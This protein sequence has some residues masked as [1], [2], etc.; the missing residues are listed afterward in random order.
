MFFDLLVLMRTT[1]L[2]LAMLFVVAPCLAAEPHLL[3]DQF[4][5]PAGFHIYRA[6]NA[7]LTGGSYD[8]TLDGQGRLLVGAGQ[9]VRRLT[10]RNGDGVYD[11]QETIADGPAVAGRGPQ[12]LLVFGD[13]LYVVAGDGVQLFSG[14]TG[15]GKLRHERR[16]GAPFNTG[17]DHAAHTVLRG[18]DNYI[19]LVTGDGAGTNGRKHITET[20]SPNRQERAA[21]VF[22]FDAAGEK[23]ECIGSGGRNP[24]SLGMNYLGEFFSFDSDMEFHVDVPF[25]RP[26]RLNHWATGGDLGWQS[27]GAFPPWY[28][29]NLPGVL[30][31]G[32]GS[33]NWGVV[34]EHTQFP[35]PYRDAFIAC[36]YT[37]KSATSGRYATSGR[38]LTFHLQ[39]EGAGWKANL[40]ELAKAKPGAQDEAGRAINFALVDVAVAPDGSLLLS[41]H[42]QGV[43]RL[44]YD[45][46][47]RPT[48]PPLAYTPKVE[49]PPLS[50]LLALPQPAAEWCRILELDLR[51][52]LGKDVTAQLQEVATNQSAPLRQR[53]RALRLLAPDFDILDPSF[54]QALAGDR[55]PEIRGQAAWLTGIRG[56]VEEVARP[57]RMLADANPFVRRRAAE[58]LMRLHSEKASDDLVAT[59]DDDVRAVRYAAMVAL[60][61][62]DLGELWENIPEGTAPQTQLRLLV[63]GHLRGQRPPAGTACKW[64]HRLLGGAR[65]SDEDTLDLLRVLQLYRGEVA[66]EDACHTAVRKWLRAHFPDANH[67]VRWEQ[68]RL[69]GMYQ[70]AE[71]FPKLVQEL[72]QAD[73]H[74]T[75]FH[76]AT[77]LAEIPR[78][79]AGWDIAAQQKLCDWLIS[80]Q[81]GWFA[82]YAGKG[83][84][85]PQF[86]ATT[87]NK[88]GERHADGLARQ[89]GRLE[90]DGPLAQVVFTHLSDVPNADQMLIDRYQKTTADGTRANIVGL[91]SKTATAKAAQFFLSELTQTQPPPLR[92]A[93]LLAFATTQDAAKHPHLF[94]PTLVD[95]D[96]RELLQAS[97]QGLLASNRRLGDIQGID[98][99]KVGKLTGGQAVCFRL[100]ELMTQHP[101]DAAQL[102]Q[103]LMV[104]TGH[105]PADQLTRPRCIWSSATQIRGDRAWFAKTFEVPT[106]VSKAELVITCDNQF[107]AFV[108]GQQVAA[109]SDWTKPLR[110]DLGKSLRTG[111]NLITVA[112]Q[113][114][115]GPAGLVATLSWSTAAGSSG[116][117]ATNST[118]LVTRKPTNNWATEGSA[119]GAWQLSTDVSQPTRNALEAWQSFVKTGTVEQH[120]TIQEHWHKWYLKQFRQAFVARASATAPR[121]D[122]EIH[123]LI[124]GLG[125]LEGDAARGRAIY[126]KASCYACHGGLDDRQTTIFGPALSGVV[127]RLKRGELADAIVFP[128]KQVVERFKATVVVTDDG[129]LLRGF[130]TERTDEFLSITDLQNRV[131]RLAL[132]E[133]E[134]IKAQD[135]SLMPAKLLNRFSDEEIR[136]LL[137]FLNSLR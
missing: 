16:L 111:T 96:D 100:L 45:S 33:P 10:D 47:E 4:V 18:L 26:V 93:L 122:G 131:T 128:S 82:E 105:Q 77:A 65:L 136:D 31:V 115:D 117:V 6:A 97:L 24:P 30:D 23:W 50:R 72:V 84:Q 1:C 90:P 133:V 3:D 61:H 107:T 14:V 104:L 80:T 58:A 116:G 59:L 38:L 49:S 89:F 48:V 55:E 68:A 13:Y 95:S 21:S 27:V 28:V 130:V 108:N 81:T 85:F 99:A 119:Q 106:G 39:R 123:A 129:Q 94:I 98:A 51:R 5:L 15:T 56:Q 127:Q 110:V 87:L 124:T 101:D 2:G 17:G 9:S 37:W 75:Q 40:S 19:Y 46:D 74:V 32:R 69:L 102:E 67:T 91:L 62:R 57:I 125:D 126:L 134:S 53:L 137:A 109:S 41:D 71:A 12:G 132:S 34:Y 42:N 66:M 52:Q 11:L 73:D 92:K 20:T 54:L 83:L 8:L 118:W 43:W 36:D 70:V 135:V 88:L 44:F 86:W 25:Y 63:A 22:R 35:R 121:S 29:D 112:G 114:E 113:N 60:A 64:I 79:N 76:L 103:T 120:L 7:E 78:P